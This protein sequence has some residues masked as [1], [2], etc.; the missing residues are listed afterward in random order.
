MRLSGIY[1]L[2]R[3]VISTRLSVAQLTTTGLTMDLRSFEIRF[4]GP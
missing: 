4:A 1:K 3:L 2:I